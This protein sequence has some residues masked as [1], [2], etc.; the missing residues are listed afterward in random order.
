MN[1]AIKGRKFEWKIRDEYRAL[2]YHVTRSAGSKGWFDLIAVHPET[3]HIV[4]L[5]LKKG[6]G[7][8]SQEKDYIF[9]W[10]PCQLNAEFKFIQRD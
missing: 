9:P 6:K 8:K 2:G 4:F 7:Q 3:K 5:Q 10:L 1:R